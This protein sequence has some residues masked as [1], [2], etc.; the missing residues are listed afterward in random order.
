MPKAIVRLDYFR[1]DFSMLV[2]A[3]DQVYF[4]FVIMLKS[5]KL[6]IFLLFRK[7]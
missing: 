3:L 4:C 7:S 1:E 5:W 2:R 6:S